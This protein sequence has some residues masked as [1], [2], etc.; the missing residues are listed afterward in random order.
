M[1]GVADLGD[2]PHVRKVERCSRVRAVRDHTALGD[3]EIGRSFTQL[4][5]DAS[6]GVTVEPNVAT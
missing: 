4:A 6:R 5:H 2:H 3:D 1:V